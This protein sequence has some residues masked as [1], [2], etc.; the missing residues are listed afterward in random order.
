M[1]RRP[2]LSPKRDLPSPMAIGRRAAL[3]APLLGLAGR[4]GASGDY[5]GGRTATV[6]MPY[7][8]GGLVS[9]LGDTINRGLMQRLGGSFVTDFRPGGSTAIGARQVARAR[10]DGLTLLMGSVTT[11]TVLPFTVRNLGY[12]PLADF[13][14]LTMIGN[15]L[16]V[17]VGNP[18]WPDLPALLDEARRR[19][20]ALSY[21]SFG[22]ATT[23]HLVMLDFLRRAGLEMLHVSFG[24]SA[25]A[26]TEIIGGRV[27]VM[28]STLASAKPHLEAGRLRGFGI[29]S[30]QRTAALPDIPTL[31]E[32]G[33]NDFTFD[34]W[35]SMATPA[36]TPAAITGALE[37]ALIATFADPEA[38]ARLDTLGLEAT[39]PG[40]AAVQE[41]IRRNLRLN[42]ELVN[43]AGITAE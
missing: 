24:G 11:F 14:H 15:T 4:A 31:I 26:I 34:A 9:I 43:Q 33:F 32:Q 17:L 28:F 36:R 12:D 20:G 29:P 6:V 1:H 37:A 16:F 7:T 13:E 35:L 25:A 10:P 40:A 41:S 18:R 2:F 22:A 21:A 5:P 19:P 42:G 39:P 30:A 27:D 8:A 38:R 23:A 3:A